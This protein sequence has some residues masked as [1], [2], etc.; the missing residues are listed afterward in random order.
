MSGIWVMVI[1]LWLVIV[2]VIERG[3]WPLAGLVAMVTVDAYL[4]GAPGDDG[5]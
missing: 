1:L 4:I 2:S 3:I 5:R